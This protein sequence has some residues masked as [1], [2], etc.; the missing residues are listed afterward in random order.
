MLNKKS[1]SMSIMLAVMS[2]AVIADD[3][4]QDMSDPLAVFTQVGAGYTDKGINLKIGQAYDTGSDKTSGMNV[5]ELKGIY[6][7]VFGW[8]SKGDLDNSVDSFRFRNFG[9]N[10]ENG[11][12]AQLDINYSLQPSL[13]ADDTADISYSVIQALPSFGNFNLY[14]LA[15]IG[16]SLGNNAWEDDGSRDSGYSIMGTYGL[17]GMYSKYQ[18]TDSIWLNYNP[19]WLSTISGADNYT[20]NYYGQDTSHI[21]THEFAMSYQFTPRF[22]LRY[23]ANWNKNIDFVDG[24][25][26]LEFNY[27]L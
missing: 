3:E 1:S 9:V 5:I 10:L 13:V 27:Q 6:G 12:A 25:H 18:V 16:I 22:N 11:R 14:P 23:F 20:D 26:R 21:F 8:R 19:F 4:V 24:D 17:I 2:F 7:D 15:G